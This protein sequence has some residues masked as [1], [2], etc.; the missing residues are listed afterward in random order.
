M[1]IETRGG[2]RRRETPSQQKNRRKP[3]DRRRADSFSNHR[4]CN[5]IFR[6]LCQDGSR[7]I[8]YYVDFH[9]EICKWLSLVVAE[10]DWSRGRKTS[11]CRH[12]E[13]WRIGPQT[14]SGSESREKRVRAYSEAELHAALGIVANGVAGADPTQLV[15]RKLLVVN[16]YNSD[17]AHNKSYTPKNLCRCYMKGNAPRWE[18]IHCGLRSVT[19]HYSA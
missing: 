11:S 10:S 8:A 3:P 15:E 9:V 17:S 18:S 2:V 4:E 7:G 5:A 19:N 12:L 1:S 6:W 13:T 14:R 16:R